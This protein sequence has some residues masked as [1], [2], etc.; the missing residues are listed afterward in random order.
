VPSRSMPHNSTRPSPA[1]QS[2]EISRAAVRKT[3]NAHGSGFDRVGA[4]QDEAN[5]GDAPYDSIVNGVPYDL[6]DYWTQV[7]PEIA[8]GNVWPPLKG[9]EPFDPA[10]PPTCGGT[11]EQGYSLFY[12]VP[13]DYVA[14]DM[15]TSPGTM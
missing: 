6:E 8:D 14:W 4:F 9:L 13:D 12:C 2:C 11:V 7:Y 5:G 10:K 1:F 3:P 15:I